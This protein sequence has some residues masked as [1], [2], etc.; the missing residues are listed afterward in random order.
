V[1]KTLAQNWTNDRPM[2]LL[3]YI[4]Q[5]KGKGSRN[6]YAVVDAYVLA[7]LYLL[8]ERGLSTGALVTIISVFN[9]DKFHRLHTLSSG[10][11]WAIVTLAP[12]EVTIGPMIRPRGSEPNTRD[13]SRE[14]LDSEPFVLQVFVNVRQLRASVDD[15]LGALANRK[16]E[17]R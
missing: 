12:D 14:L 3:P 15:R 10:S 8:K 17:E 1:P 6:V 13:E 9:R 16:G 4:S 2:R 5:G 11:D 7:F